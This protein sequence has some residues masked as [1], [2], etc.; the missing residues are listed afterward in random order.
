MTLKSLAGSSAMRLML[1]LLLACCVLGCGGGEHHEDD[2]EDHHIP[3]HRPANLSAAVSQLE[4][5][6]AALLKAIESKDSSAETL[7]SELRDIVRWVPEIAADSD[8]TKQPW[9]EV[10]AAA[11][12]LEQLLPAQVTGF[13]ALKAGSTQDAEWRR[14]VAEL[15]KHAPEEGRNGD[16]TNGTDGTDDK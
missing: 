15:R 8:M 11:L 13:A 14:L 7:F 3:P 6:P 12:K 1:L 5:R 10:H 9:D 4:E 2:E 16:G